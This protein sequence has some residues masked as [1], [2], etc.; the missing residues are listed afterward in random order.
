VPIGNEWPSNEEIFER[1]V[2]AV[3]VIK[4]YEMKN[5]LHLKGNITSNLIFFV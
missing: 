1:F 3:N 2:E 5:E 4:N